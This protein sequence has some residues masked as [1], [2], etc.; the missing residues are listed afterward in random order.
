LSDQGARWLPIGTLGD[1]IALFG[2]P[3]S[4]TMRENR[5]VEFAY[6]KGF[7]IIVQANSGLSRP[8]EAYRPRLDD[9]VIDV[10]I[11]LPPTNESMPRQKWCGFQ[12]RMR[13]DCRVHS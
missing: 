13:K 1:F 7:A 2:P 10:E 8:G 6:A 12:S 4:V 5:F 11:P 9:S 3:M